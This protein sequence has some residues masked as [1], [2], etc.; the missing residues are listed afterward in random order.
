[1]TNFI[2]K[3]GHILDNF[4]GNFQKYILIKNYSVY[5]LGNFRKNGYY[6]FSHL[7]TLTVRWAEN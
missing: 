5:F 7:V 4:G 3:V 6:L 2:A 1:M